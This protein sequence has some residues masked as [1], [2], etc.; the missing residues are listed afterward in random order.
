LQVLLER[1]VVVQIAYDEMF[2]M[3]RAE[4]LKDYGYEV[5]SVLGNDEA[6][7]VL[8]KTQRHHLYIVGHAA[9]IEVRREMA[10]WLKTNFPDAKILALNPPEHT[11][12]TEA[13]YNLAVS[14]S[15]EWLAI[16]AK[17]AT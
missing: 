15:E 11:K 2:R 3:S 9:P 16:I 13:D 6:K 5:I 1:N 14:E 8:S 12:L 17:E 4:L 10:R 7:R